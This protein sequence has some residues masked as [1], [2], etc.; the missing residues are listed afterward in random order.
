M[1]RTTNARL[2]GFTFL[3]YIATGIASMVLFGRA[4]RGEGI[5][6]KLASVAQHPAELRAVVLLGLLTTLSAWVLAVTLYAI[7]RDEDPDVAMF[8]L[9][10]RFAEGV[11]GG[12]SVKTSMALLWLAT[13]TGAR[14]LDAGAARDQAAYLLSGSGG[15]IAATFFAFGSTAFCYLL[16][17]GRMIPVWLAWLGV[18]AS[19]VLV[20]AL[21]LVLAGFRE[22]NWFIWMPMLVFELVF[23]FWL[24]F[25]EIRPAG[26]E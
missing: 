7:T 23:A 1:T 3:F 5:A 20:A 18:V 16:L 11:V 6:A 24:L 8:G 2:A 22:E 9:V 14:A 25:K 12:L 21:P 19:I 4:T 10:C 26:A 15:G 13:A 17:R